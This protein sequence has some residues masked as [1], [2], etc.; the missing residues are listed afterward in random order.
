MKLRNGFVSNSSSASFV[1]KKSDLSETQIKQLLEYD[2]GDCELWDI[3]ENEE[4]VN[5]STVMDN[6]YILSFMREIGISTDKIGF[7]TSE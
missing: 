2:G 6:G 5:G 7:W 4:E 3:S 1:I